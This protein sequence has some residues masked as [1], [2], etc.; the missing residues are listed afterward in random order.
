[1]N[2]ICLT[3]FPIE[4]L[5]ISQ[6]FLLS[7]G[8]RMHA[9]LFL[10]LNRR[11]QSVLLLS[12]LYCFHSWENKNF[13]HASWPMYELFVGMLLQVNTW[14]MLSFRHLPTMYFKTYY[15]KTSKS[16]DFGTKGNTAE[17]EI[18]RIRGLWYTVNGTKELIKV[19][20]LW[21]FVI[22]FVQNGTNFTKF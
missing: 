9:L 21:E 14:E 10:D 5:N 1:M 17:C 8:R 3:S 20:I 11:K 7:F 19:P 12:L 16:A 22:T 15:T 13:Q 4:C 2:K 18:R 6:I